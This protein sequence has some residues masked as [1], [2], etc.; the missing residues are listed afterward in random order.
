MS[1]I[2]DLL[3]AS[4]IL[5]DL[6]AGTKSRLF[7]A[8]GT[9]FETQRGIVRSGVVDSLMAREK[10]GSTGLGQGIAIPHGRIK[11]L[12][13]ALGAFVRLRTPI[14]FDAPDGKPVG[15]VFVLL[16]PEHATEQHLQLLSELA[17]MFSDK[18]FRESI[19]KCKDA[20]EIHKLIT[21]WEPNV[22]N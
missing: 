17:Q 19:L 15:H 4:S 14:D 16:V 10:L 3:P 13:N 22:A 21:D 9:L 6:D 1:Q 20:A 12:K 18:Q 8:V 7:D 2:A 5:L 11:G